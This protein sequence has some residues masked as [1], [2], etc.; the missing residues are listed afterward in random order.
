M[1][2]LIMYSRRVSTN[3]V[4]RLLAR[5]GLFGLIS[6]CSLCRCTTNEENSL[7]CEI[8]YPRYYVKE[9]RNWYSEN[10]TR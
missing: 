2:K 6:F 1:N 3:V 8:R 10:H 4:G 5:S 7:N 9:D